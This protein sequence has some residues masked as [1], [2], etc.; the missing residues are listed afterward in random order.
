LDGLYK[1]KAEGIRI[2]LRMD[3]GSE[4]LAI[5]TV[6]MERHRVVYKFSA[7]F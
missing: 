6:L 3:S 1:H 2:V 7:G 5:K 4:G